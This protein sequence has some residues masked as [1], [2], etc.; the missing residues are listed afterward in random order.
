[1]GAL[2][3]A[4]ENH[5]LALVHKF[6]HAVPLPF[7]LDH[8]PP[9]T[10]APVLTRAS[11]HSNCHE[12]TLSSFA[13]LRLIGRSSLP[14]RLATT[15]DSSIIDMNVCTSNSVDCIGIGDGGWQNREIG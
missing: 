10:P 9:Q 5:M 3:R 15:P 14:V 11:A 8:W 7:A 6:G 1:M 13:L 2:T 12:S 4:P